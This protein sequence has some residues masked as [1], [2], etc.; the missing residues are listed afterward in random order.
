M[1]E[2]LISIGYNFLIRTL[3]LFLFIVLDSQFN[4]FSFDIIIMHIQQIYY[5]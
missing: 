3:I 4:N 2:M 1:K 5:I